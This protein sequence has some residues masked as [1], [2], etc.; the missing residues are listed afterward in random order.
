VLTV[1]CCALQVQAVRVVRDKAS[2]IGKGF[3]YVM[4]KDKVRGTGVE[5]SGL[6]Q[7]H[8]TCMLLATPLPTPA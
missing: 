3:A 7:V 4:F 8:D 6:G 2:N 1:P 5:G